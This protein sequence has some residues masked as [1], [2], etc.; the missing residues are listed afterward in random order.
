MPAS[1]KK[2]FD[3]GKWEAKKAAP[4]KKVEPKKTA[5]KK[6]FATSEVFVESRNTIVKDG[7]AAYLPDENDL[8]DD[9]I[10]D[11]D[12]DKYFYPTRRLWKVCVPY[13]AALLKNI[14]K[15]LHLGGV[16]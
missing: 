5:E 2:E 12:W 6:K 1:V 4:K 16:E 14:E 9:S 10:L 13:D 7:F 15:A 8:V 3:A 11:G